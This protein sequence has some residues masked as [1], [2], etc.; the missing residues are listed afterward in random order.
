ME[1]SDLMPAA[2]FFG[3]SSLL[4]FILRTDNVLL[5][6]LSSQYVGFAA[7]LLS[8]QFVHS[9]PRQRGS[10]LSRWASPS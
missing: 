9:K 8:S 3:V 2:V 1:I 5:D 7:A 10:P 6:A 4:L